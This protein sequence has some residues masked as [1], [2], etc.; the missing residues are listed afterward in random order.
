[1]QNTLKTICQFVVRQLLDDQLSKNATLLAERIEV[2]N[3]LCFKYPEAL[4]HCV[5]EGNKT[6]Y[7]YYRKALSSH[8]KNKQTICGPGGCISGMRG[9]MSHFRFKEIEASSQELMKDC[10]S[11]LWHWLDPK[12]KIPK[13]NVVKASLRLLEEHP[14]IVAKYLIECVRI[15]TIC[16]TLLQWCKHV[17]REVRSAALSAFDA[18]SSQLKKYPLSRQEVEDLYRTYMNL[19]EES[20]LRCVSLSFRG[21]GSISS[22]VASYHM[23]VLDDFIPSCWRYWNLVL[24]KPDDEDQNN[25]MIEILPNF[26]ISVA[27]VILNIPVR[28]HHLE[29]FDL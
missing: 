10:I 16:N 9:L 23:N 24:S 20:D 5:M 7:E 6:A 11:T 15:P 4:D 29:K 2:C 12:T 17:D 27:D 14:N 8:I 1:M 3:C 21:R 19:M 25:M 26:L 28:P 18:W 22:H 13:Y